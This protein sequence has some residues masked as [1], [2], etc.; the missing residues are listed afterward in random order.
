MFLRKLWI[1]MW[2]IERWQVRLIL[3]D[4]AWA[5]AMHKHFLLERCVGHGLSSKILMVL[6]LEVAIVIVVD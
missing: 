5:A 6:D 1:T 4:T 3:N 2:K